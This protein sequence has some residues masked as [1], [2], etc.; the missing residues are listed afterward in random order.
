VTPSTSKE[1]TPG[2]EGRPKKIFDGKY[3]VCSPKGMPQTY[4]SPVFREFAV[5]AVK[6]KKTNVGPK[7]LE[8]AL[9]SEE[10]IN[11][12]E[13]Q[14]QKKK[15]D[16]VAKDERKKQREVAK[17]RKADEEVA[18]KE[19]QALRAQQ[20]AEKRR[21]ADEK[22]QVIEE[23][24]L[25]LATIKKEKQREKK[26]KAAW[27]KGEDPDMSDEDQ[28][29]DDNNN[30]DGGEEEVFYGPVERVNQC[31]SCHKVFNPV[32]SST[33]L[34]CDECGLTWWCFLCA[35]MMCEAGEDVKTK[36]LICVRCNPNQE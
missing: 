6:R 25:R 27:R 13:E 16:E 31:E 28:R 10:Y 11:K 4:V 35:A 33:A 26:Q 34:G 36:T 20:A 22:K 18:R 24:K 14:V 7:K 23:K 9:T 30:E 15:D 29:E 5:P 2:S 19:R 3:V 1:S 32:E 12:V 21:L 8:F 17:K